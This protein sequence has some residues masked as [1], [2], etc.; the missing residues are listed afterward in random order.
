[1]LASRVYR[2]YKVTNKITGKIYIGQTVRTLKA[3]WADH[4]CM[5][6][7]KHKS[8]LKTA[9]KKYKKHSFTIELLAIVFSLKDANRLEHE[10]IKSYDSL[11]PKGYNLKCGGGSFGSCHPDTKVKISKVQEHKRKQIV[12]ATTGDI[13]STSREAEEKTG[14]T[15]SQIIRCCKQKP[16]Y[17]TAGGFVFRYT[18]DWDGKKIRPEDVVD[19]Y[20]PKA[21]YIVVVRKNNEKIG[22]FDSMTECAKKFGFNADTLFNFQT[23][24]FKYKGYEIEKEYNYAV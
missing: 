1:M 6:S 11:S 14:I 10:L 7:Y 5:K 15:R 4:C 3:R 20:K 21:N 18:Q 22:V 23:K 24:S 17:L 19:N 9:I 13:F 8:A 16:N 12:N 2:L